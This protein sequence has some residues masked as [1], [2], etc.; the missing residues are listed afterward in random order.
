MPNT[1]CGKEHFAGHAA[2]QPVNTGDAVSHGN[3]GANFV[4][5]DDL[6]IIFNLLS[7]NTCYFVCL[8]IRHSSS[9]TRP[10]PAVIAAK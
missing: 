6:L 7:Q 3:H 4:H 10:H 9:F 5:R 1:S 2:V 8:D